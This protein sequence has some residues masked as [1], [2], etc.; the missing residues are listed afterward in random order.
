[1]GEVKLISATSLKPGRYVVF[2]DQCCIVKSIDVSRP[3]KH[4]HAKCRIEAVTI[5]DGKKIIK[6]M[7]GHDKIGSPVI[8]KNEAQVLSVDGDKANVMD[9]KT[10]ETYDLEIPSNLK[11][12]VK[13]GVKV[14]YWELL[15]DKIVKEVREE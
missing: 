7:P 2:D 8:E 9:L 14:I 6:I 5:K 15:K 11:D 3:G 1:M 4:G 13:D 10:F 12:K